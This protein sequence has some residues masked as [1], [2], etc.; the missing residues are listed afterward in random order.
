[1]NIRLSIKAKHLI[2]WLIPICFIVLIKILSNQH[3][4]VEKYYTLHIYQKIATTQRT[5]FGWLPFS[6]GDVLYTVLIISICYF[7]VWFVLALIKQKLHIT[8]IFPFCAKTIYIALWVFILFEVLWG[9]NYSRLGIANQLQLSNTQYTENELK[10]TICILAEELNATRLQLGDS[11]YIY[12]KEDSIFKLAIQSYE[13]STTTFPFLQYQ[14]VSVKKSLLS[15]LVNYAGYSGYYNP[16]TGEAQINNDLPKF[17]TPFVV[18]HEMAHQLG[19]ASESEANFVGYLTASQS[20]SALLRYS[21]LYEL[22]A[23]ANGTLMDVDF[24]SAFLN[25]QSLNN[26]VKKDRKTYRDYI[27]GKQNKVEPV[28][29]KVYDQYLKANQ[30]QSGINSYDE[31]VGWVIAYNRN[32]GKRTNN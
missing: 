16:L 5:L 32:N 29:K 17:I 27:L 10:E 25:L 21:A 6:I 9:L 4:W 14:P 13:K 20:S 22:F 28:I 30:Q 12:P 26:L 23:V 3:N 1:M 18:C 24:W 2:K 7:L 8:Q 11:N 31:V 15:E 19:Y